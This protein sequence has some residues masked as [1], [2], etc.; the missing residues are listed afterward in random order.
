MA[1]VLASVIISRA[2]ERLTDTQ[3]DYRWSNPTLLQ[4]LAD[5]RRDLFSRRPYAFYV[6]AIVHELPSFTESLTADVAVLDAFINPLAAY[7]AARAIGQDAEHAA[8]QNLAKLWMGEYLA[9]I[10]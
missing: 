4:H 7:V 8:N 2:R 5:G 1:S 3:E 9:G 10:Q 6:S